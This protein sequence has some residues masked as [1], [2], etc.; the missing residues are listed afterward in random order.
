V[1]TVNS[2]IFKKYQEI[3]HVKICNADAFY[4]LHNTFGGKTVFSYLEIS[5]TEVDCTFLYNCSTDKKFFEKEFR[6]FD[7]D[8]FKQSE[9]IFKDDDT[10]SEY[11]AFLEYHKIEII[12]F[13]TN[14]DCEQKMV[15]IC[16]AIEC[17]KNDARAIF[18]ASVASETDKPKELQVQNEF[19]GD[20]SS[21]EFPSDVRILSELL[22]E[23]NNISIKSDIQ[24]DALFGYTAYALDTHKKYAPLIIEYFIE[25]WNKAQ[26][27]NRCTINK[28]LEEYDSFVALNISNMLLD[29]ERLPS[30][31]ELPATNDFLKTRYLKEVK[32][33][34]LGCEKYYT[35]KCE[36][37]KNYIFQ[38]GV[39]NRLQYTRDV[40][41]IAMEVIDDFVDD[42]TFAKNK[43]IENVCDDN[44]IYS[45]Q[46]YIATVRLQR[47]TVYLKGILSEIQ[48]L[49]NDMR[50]IAY[51]LRFFNNQ[52]SQI[53]EEYESTYH[54]EKMLSTLKVSIFSRKNRKEEKKDEIKIQTL[55]LNNLKKYC[56]S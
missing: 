24:H 5:E 21:S 12:L 35:T 32:P 44:L 8:T 17:T 7:F 36:E 45:A 43:I 2:S 40:S 53:K 19:N 23:L 38:L 49:C 48:S 20:N 30:A 4:A 10:F 39:E 33:V 26:E 41:G 56:Q 42:K 55:L 25:R 18:E 50:Q 11:K 13:D 31:E 3:K 47:I 34:L 16:K 46:I 15:E 29:F 28:I 6:N 14:L 54:G 51:K 27:I 22:L 37:R 52:L 9:F 1:K